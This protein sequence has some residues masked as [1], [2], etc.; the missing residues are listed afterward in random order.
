MSL[1]AQCHKRKNTAKQER[2]P[3]KSPRSRVVLVDEGGWLEKG[4]AE[5]S[6]ELV[7][8]F[9]AACIGTAGG[10]GADAV[11]RACCKVVCRPRGPDQRRGRVVLV[12][13]HR[14]T[15]VSSAVDGQQALKRSKRTKAEQAAEPTQP[16]KGKAKGKAA[17]VKPAPSQAGGSRWSC[18]TGQTREHCQPKGKEY[19]GR[20]YKRL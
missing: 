5:A 3:T 4:M 17:K 11:L 8:F 10:W 2:R 7:V 12:D 18:A 19:P 13:E 20:G 16:T 15:R 14:T 6:M 1:V 9:G